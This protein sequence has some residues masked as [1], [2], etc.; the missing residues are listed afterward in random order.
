MPPDDAHGDKILLTV[1]AAPEFVRLARLTAAG[2]ATRIG[3]GYD[4]VEDLRIAVGE[5][6][7][8]LIGTGTRAGSLSL[9]FTLGDDRVTIDVTGEFQGEVGEPADTALSDQILDAVVDDHGVDVAA[10]HVWLVKTHGS[11]DLT[12]GLV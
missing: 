9:G 4:E 5:A 3:M 7:S 11:D 8:L 12:V 6:C 1:P 2:L 10:D